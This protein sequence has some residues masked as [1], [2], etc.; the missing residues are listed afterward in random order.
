MLHNKGLYIINSAYNSCVYGISHVYY[1]SNFWK[2]QV[3]AVTDFFIQFVKTKVLKC[4]IF[5][6]RLKSPSPGQSGARLFT[7]YHT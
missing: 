4:L 7:L 1:R 3:D 6:V 5:Q 2:N